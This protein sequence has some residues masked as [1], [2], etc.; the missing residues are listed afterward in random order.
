[1]GKQ[2]YKGDV[3]EELCC[4]EEDL[5]RAQVIMNKQRTDI[6]RLIVLLIEND[7]PIPEDLINSYIQKTKEPK[8]M[9][10]SVVDDE[11]PFY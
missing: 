11:L 5:R 2:R 7:I 4:L 3:Y 8:S 6:K 1:M 9:S 10:Q